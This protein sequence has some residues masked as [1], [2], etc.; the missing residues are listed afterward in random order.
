MTLYPY[1]G[2][3]DIRRSAMNTARLRIEVAADVARWAHTQVEPC[4]S[5]SR[6]CFQFAGIG[7]D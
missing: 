3:P 1:V 5:R 2:P 7:F 6:R 4:S